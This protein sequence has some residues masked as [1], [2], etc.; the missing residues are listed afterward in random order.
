VFAMTG[1]I[2][3]RGV[4]LDLARRRIRPVRSHLPKDNASSCSS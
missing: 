4:F 3:F 1:L 2:G